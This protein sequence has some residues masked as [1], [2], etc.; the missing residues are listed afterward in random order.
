MQV[1][2]QQPLNTMVG[3]TPNQF[4]NKPV[5]RALCTVVVGKSQDAL[6][7]LEKSLD[8]FAITKGTKSGKSIV[9]VNRNSVAALQRYASGDSTLYQRLLDRG[10]TFVA[11]KSIM[12]FVRNK[13]GNNPIPQL[14]YDLGQ[15]S[16]ANQR[17]ADLKDY[18]RATVL[19]L[20][21]PDYAFS[22]DKQ[23]QRVAVVDADSLI[24]IQPG[25]TP[26]VGKSRMPI[27]LRT[28]MDLTTPEN[29]TFSMP[30]FVFAD[31]EFILT[32]YQQ[33]GLELSRP[34]FIQSI[35]LTSHVQDSFNEFGSAK[36][37]EELTGGVI[38]IADLLQQVE[39]IAMPAETWEKLL[40][41]SGLVA[42]D[43]LLGHG[44]GVRNLIR[45]LAAPADMICFQHCLDLQQSDIRTCPRY[46]DC[47]ESL[48]EIQ[49]V[50]SLLFYQ[51]LVRL[52]LQSLTHDFDQLSTTF[53]AYL[54][55]GNGAKMANPDL[56][57]NA[58]DRQHCLHLM[59][60][61][62][63]YFMIHLWGVVEEPDVNY[64]VLFHNS[65][66]NKLASSFSSPLND[67]GFLA[68]G[69]NFRLLDNQEPRTIRA[70]G[71]EHAALLLSNASAFIQL[72]AS[73]SLECPQKTPSSQ[74]AQSPSLFDQSITGFTYGTVTGL[75][76]EL[77]S[78]TS[79]PT[80]YTWLYNSAR[81]LLF[82]GKV[83]LALGLGEHVYLQ[84]IE[85]VLPD[86]LL[87]A[88]IRPVASNT[89]LAAALAQGQTLGVL[90]SVAGYTAVRTAGKIARYVWSRARHPEQVHNKIDNN[91]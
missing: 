19:K 60:G 2:N 38:Q 17:K 8:K 25:N 74:S 80:R 91:Q 11:S 61:S 45:D 79:L 43:R 16:F 32:L 87:K 56:C 18:L 22:K 44:M 54:C 57:H 46:L 75:A 59:A 81:G 41:Q 85:P 27:G 86:G 20:L 12:K 76:D 84:Y 21:C 6:A 63:G 30:D 90:G 26:A 40:A 52:S 47:S 48:H 35:S 1:S 24:P 50:V 3:N 34:E 31:S 9:I 5:Q 70:L 88:C 66:I 83:G 89:F 77:F 29:C 72:D 64:D 62:Q 42:G 13:Y 4:G 10:V 55:C 39:W 37:A 69:C 67:W 71:K 23:L 65:T 78:F 7:W 15:L 68:T 14:L 82:G 33:L 53:D 28:H 58:L 36:L 73:W 51:P 49:G